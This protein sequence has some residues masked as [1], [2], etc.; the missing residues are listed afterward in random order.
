MRWK[1]LPQLMIFDDE[2]KFSEADSPLENQ[3]NFAYPLLISVSKSISLSEF[4]QRGWQR[5]LR[6]RCNYVNH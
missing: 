1:F 6:G 5:M 3:I 2:N 4:A